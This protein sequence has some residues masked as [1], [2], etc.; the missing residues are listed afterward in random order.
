MRTSPDFSFTVPLSTAP[1]LTINATDIALCEG[2]STTII[3]TGGN[4][5]VWNASPD[6]NTSSGDIVI[7]T[8]TS[9]STY[10][11]QSN[12]NGCNE[13]QS[14]TIQVDSPLQL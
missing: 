7:A 3:A 2:E 8:P 10:T 5:Y 4:N 1:S 6:L 14:I 9:T 11:V 12:N 13:T